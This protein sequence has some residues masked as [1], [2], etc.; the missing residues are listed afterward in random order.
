MYFFSDFFFFKSE[1]P[2]TKTIEKPAAAGTISGK[3]I[4]PDGLRGA[5]APLS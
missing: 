4:Y 5:K 2:T 3:A 1:P